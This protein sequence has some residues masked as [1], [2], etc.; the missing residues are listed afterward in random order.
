MR[1]VFDPVDWQDANLAMV[2]GERWSCGSSFLP[3]RWPMLAVFL[4]S[5]RLIHLLYPIYPLPILDRI[6]KLLYGNRSRD[7]AIEGS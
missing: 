6:T 1:P 2:W 7:I 5:T 3:L 4:R